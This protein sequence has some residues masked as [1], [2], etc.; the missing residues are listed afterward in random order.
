MLRRKTK[1]IAGAA[2]GGVAMGAAGDAGSALHDDGPGVLLT[3]G[4]VDGSWVLGREAYAERLRGMWLAECLANWTGRRTEGRWRE[5]P[6]GTDA[7]WGTGSGSSK[8]EFVLQD[9]WLADDDTDIEYVY[10]HLHALEPRYARSPLLTASVIADGWVSHINRFIWVSNERARQLMELGLTPPAT[11][12]AHANRWWLQIDAQLTTEIFGAFAPGMPGLALE[13]SML[14]IQATASGHSLHAAQWHAVVRSLA[15][16]APE[17]M[18][19]ADR[20]L[21]LATEARAYLPDGSK[22][23]EVIDF[24]VADYLDNPDPDDWERTRDLVHARY[25][26][27]AVANGW[28]YRGWT[29]S[30]VNLAGSVI[31]L[32]Y[33]G[34]DLRRTIQIATLVGWDSDN[35][36]ASM[37]ATIGLMLGEQGVRDAF[38]EATLSSRYDAAR[39][40]DDL[41]DY[42]PDDA[43]ADDSVVMI[44]DRILGVVD[45]AMGFG[46]GRV[47]SDGSGWLIPR[48]PVGDD[49][50]TLNPAVREATRSANLHVRR[51]GGTV[52]ASSDA[53]PQG[54]PRSPGYPQPGL[55][56]N[57]LEF[58]LTGETDPTE[59][60]RR[61][62][63]TDGSGVTHPTLT[64]MYSLEVEIDE[65]RFA[66]GFHLA[67][68]GGWFESMTLE[69]RS[70]GVWVAPELAEADSPLPPVPYQVLRFRLAA[71]MAVD[72]VRLS[73]PAGGTDG[74]VTCA[75]IDA[76]F[77]APPSPGLGYNL[78]RDRA[79]DVEDLFEWERAPT[80]VNGD[81]VI[82]G[83]DREALLRVVRWMELED[84]SAG[85]R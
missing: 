24:V 70:G 27:N 67:E 35:P 73:G 43:Q 37:G 64:V 59:V 1:L 23:S 44:A 60:D 11:G 39:T 82:D 5:P 4:P 77:P 33:G 57:A 84:M 31:A 49:R 66:G 17:S 52:T 6:F 34:G 79:V 51:M 45:R 36:S 55:F 2:I 50:L 47:A 15:V 78:N 18:S 71:P 58:D 72:G 3:P 25:Q 38:S 28:R 74:F 53:I 14:P 40:R 30:S 63:S 16:V 20:V 80:D 10:L 62:F 22:A 65:V 7:D 9:P 61:M 85:R 81:G 32:L 12:M 83:A 69:V 76:M 26:L 42:L 46:G 75:E 8:I 48:L 29:E 41:P 21:W 56:A 19:P 13:L 68:S 54:S